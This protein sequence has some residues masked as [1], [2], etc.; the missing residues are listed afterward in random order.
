MKSTKSFPRAFSREVALNLGRNAMA[1]L[2]SVARNTV[3][4]ANSERKLR[5]GLHIGSSSHN[6]SKGCTSLNSKTVSYSKSIIKSKLHTELT[7]TTSI[8]SPHSETPIPISTHLKC[9]HIARHRQ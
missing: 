6:H 2:S 9:Q 5:H 8:S 3:L 1:L 4:S 7:L